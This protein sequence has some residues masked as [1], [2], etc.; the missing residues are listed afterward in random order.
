VIKE[1]VGYEIISQSDGGDH[2]EHID[3]T[4]FGY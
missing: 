4:D 2:L 3:Y 1:I